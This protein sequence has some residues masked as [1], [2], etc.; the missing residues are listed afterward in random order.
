MAGLPG[1]TSWGG[2]CIKAPFFWVLLEIAILVAKKKKKTGKIT[3]SLR[4]WFWLGQATDWQTSHKFNR[5]ITWNDTTIVYLD[6]SLMFGKAASKSKAEY[7]QGRLER[8]LM[9]FSC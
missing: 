7:I 8:A 3:A 2:G 6:I 5:V 1:G 9:L 4:F